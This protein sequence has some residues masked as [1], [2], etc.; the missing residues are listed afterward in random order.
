MHYFW[1]VVFSFMSIAAGYLGYMYVM[2]QLETGNVRDDK[3]KNT[4]TPYISLK[5]ATYVSRFRCVVR[6]ATSPTCR[7]E[8]LC[9]CLFP[10]V[11]CFK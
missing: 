6:L 7:A 4:K 5:S 10:Y 3:K 2:R 11:I 9:K 1:L 8:V